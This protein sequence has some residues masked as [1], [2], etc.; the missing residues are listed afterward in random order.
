MVV[1]DPPRQTVVEIEGIEGLLLA[2]LREDVPQELL[3]L[4]SYVRVE[5]VNY[6]ETN[7]VEIN[8]DGIHVVGSAVVDVD[9]QYGGGQERDGLDYT[10]DVPFRFDILLILQR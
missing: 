10:I 5:D 6:V 8:A 2:H 3:D 4:S 9:L 7:S 1:I